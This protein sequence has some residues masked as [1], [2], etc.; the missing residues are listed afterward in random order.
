MLEQTTRDVRVRLLDFGAAQSR[1]EFG[2]IKTLERVSKLVT[3]NLRAY[4]GQTEVNR[5]IEKTLREA[6]TRF[7]YLNNGLTA[8][9]ERY[10]I[11]SNDVARPT[12]RITAYGFSIINGAQTMGSV[13]QVFSSETAQPVHGFVMLK[14]ISLERLDPEEDGQLF[15][16]RITRTTNFQNRI[17]AQDLAALHPEHERIHDVLRLSGVLYHYKQGAEVPESDE[18]NFTM[19]EAAEAGACLEQDKACMLVAKQLAYRDALWSLEPEVDAKPSL[20]ERVFPH[21]RSAL[22]TWRAVQ[23]LRLVK[24]SMRG[25]ARVET[26]P[27]KVFFQNAHALVLNVVFLR[28]RAEQG[29]E[30]TLPQATQDRIKADAQQCAE[31][32]W[33]VCEESGRVSRRAEGG[34]EQAQSFKVI[35]RNQTDCALLRH[36]LLAKLSRGPQ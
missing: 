9:C 6:P 1:G 31:T 19:V 28:L 34:Y 29:E 5:D 21:E 36:A 7:F 30:L 33:T 12:K 17:G 13:A 23:T 22:A 26:G 2:G 27:R 18:S 14:L 32:L 11:H 24:S 15:A 8:Y 25:S 10:V 16:E 3:A 20:H 35:F 4:K